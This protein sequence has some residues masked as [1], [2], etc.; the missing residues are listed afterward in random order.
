MMDSHISAAVSAGSISTDDQEALGNALDAID[1][2]LSAS[3]TSGARPSGDMKARMDSLIDQQVEAGT[4]T[5]EQA[6]EL[7]EL[8]A[9][10]PASGVQGLG[11]PGGPGGMGC[12]GGP[13]PSSG[14]EDDDDESVDATEA[15]AAQLDAIMAFLENLR[16]SL[17]NGLY[18]ES[19]TTSG[20]GN[21]G[22]VVDTQA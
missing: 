5:D 8:F 18:G 21:S 2:T 16:N 15:A 11:G 9:A 12:A 19:G 17:S 1:A 14:S 4:L 13:P 3:R 7:K 10:G 22:L 6:E 20:G